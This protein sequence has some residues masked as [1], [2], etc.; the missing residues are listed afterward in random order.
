MNINK[1]KRTNSQKRAFIKY[2]FIAIFLVINAVSFAQNSPP[3]AIIDVDTTDQ[4]TTLNVPA[5]GILANDT[6]A[7][8]DTLTV[9][10]F[11]INGTTYAAGSTVNLT[12]GVITINADGSY[13]FVPTAGFNGDVSTITCVISDGTE[14]TTSFFFL[15]VETTYDLL[16]ISGVTSCNQGYISPS[17]DFPNGAYRI[18]YSIQVRNK[19]IAK[20][21]HDSSLIRGIDLEDDLNAVFGKCMYTLN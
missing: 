6:D 14:T 13:I 4:D 15:T 3:N 20:D 17:T 16:E 7:D 19:S 2:L 21:Y 9:L 18:A 12:E 11:I 10:E 5:P 1:I 8:G